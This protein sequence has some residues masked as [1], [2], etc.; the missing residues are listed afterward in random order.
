LRYAG[1]AAPARRA[2][3]PPASVGTVRRWVEAIMRR[4]GVVGFNAHAHACRKGYA[5]DLLRANNRP[6][7]VARA[8]HHRSL[9]TTLRYYDKRTQ[10]EVLANL[11]FPSHRTAVSI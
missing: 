4:A 8:L 1:R 7:V 3:A 11:K 9:D 6:E 10:D 5:S 2:P